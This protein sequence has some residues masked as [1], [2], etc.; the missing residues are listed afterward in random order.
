MT[1]KVRDFDV[2]SIPGLAAL[3]ETARISPKHEAF[4]DV[5]NAGMDVWWWWLLWG[6]CMCG[7][8][9]RLTV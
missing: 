2:V 8:G 7:W 3:V 4:K 9:V 6:V 1:H 5:V